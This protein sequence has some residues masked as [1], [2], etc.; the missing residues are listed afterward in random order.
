MR[1]DHGTVHET[2]LVLVCP[3]ATLGGLARDLPLRRVRL[4]MM[5]TAP[6]GEDLTTSIA[7]GDSLRYY[8]GF[9]GTALDELTASEEQRP[10]AAQHRMQLLCVQRLHG[11][12]TIGD[13]HAYD[14]PFD[15]DVDEEPY[16]HLVAVT[17]EFLGRRLPRVVRRSGPVCTA[18]ASTPR[19]R[20]PREGRR[21]RMGRRRPGWPRYDPRPLSRRGDRRPARPLTSRNRTPRFV[22]QGD[23]GTYSEYI[24][25]PAGVTTVPVPAA[26]PDVVAAPASCATATAVAVVETAGDLDGRRVVVCG[27]GMLGVTAVAM[28]A[29][30]GADVMIM[31][32]DPQHAA[33][34]DRFGAVLDDG[35][36]AGIALDFSGSADAI[37]SLV[38]R[39]D[40]GGRLV[41][42][43]SSAPSSPSMRCEKSCMRRRA[44]GRRW[45]RKGFADVR[46]GHGHRSLRSLRP[47]G[48]R[49]YR[50]RGWARR[51]SAGPWV[52]S[53]RKH[54]KEPA[55][56]DHRGI[57]L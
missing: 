27:A 43:G 12:L 41:L 25:L 51:P 11:D 54:G 33:R 37:A 19:A 31:D 24:V 22:D 52:P 57:H 32:T 15:F 10:V 18:S 48:A 38:S 6:L 49:F 56:C 53:L 1:D 34:A 26:V 21:R 47:R 55:H 7:D 4:Q 36:P 45:S 35:G 40:V 8:P 2:D 42:A 28:C 46:F 29:E 20:A 17:E 3:G 9:A 14:E 23:V 30:A 39:L 50:R 16:D 13:T 5:Q 44:F